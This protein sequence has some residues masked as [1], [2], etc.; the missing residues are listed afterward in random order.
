MTAKRLF[1]LLLLALLILPGMAQADALT[2][3]K[4][5]D[6]KQLF[7]ISKIDSELSSVI[8]ISI[9]QAEAMAVQKGV[10]MTPEVKRVISQEL[11]SLYREKI[12]GSGGLCDQLVP[13]YSELYTHQE[14]K[15]YIAFYKTPLGRKV[16]DSTGKLAEQVTMIFL[17][18]NMQIGQEMF[19]RV[20]SAL[21]REGLLD[22]P[23][24]QEENQPSAP[25]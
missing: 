13:V 8:D 17:G 5:A 20:F 11:R 18:I 6:I 23:S 24:S 4:A 22:F 2:P 10:E 19:V 3:Q 15:Q 7:R 21:Q 25:L 16:A 9:A 12:L 14:V 1:P